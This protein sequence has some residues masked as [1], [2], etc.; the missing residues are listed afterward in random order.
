MKRPVHI[1]LTTIVTRGFQ[2]E[3]TGSDPNETEVANR[4]K[5]QAVLHTI[6]EIGVQIADFLN[7]GK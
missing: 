7:R 6:E 2:D 1:A 3:K 5:N 4:I